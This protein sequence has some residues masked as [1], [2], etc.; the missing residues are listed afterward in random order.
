MLL[1]GIA[2]TVAGGATRLENVHLQFTMPQ[3]IAPEWTLSS[4]FS[5]AIPLV[6]VSLTGQFLPGMA[7]LQGAGYT[8][9]ARPIFAATSI[10][11]AIVALF[12]GITIVIAAITA[13]LCTGSDAHENPGKRYIAG[14]ANGIFYL[15]GGCFAGSIVLL[16]TALPGAFIA[17]LAGL[18]L[19]GAIMAN[20]MG[21]VGEASHREASIITFLVTASGMT[22]QGLGSAFWGVIIGLFT[23]AVLHRPWRTEAVVS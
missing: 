9:P 11:S 7:I 15:V 6:L 3:F 20:L 1:A 12:G 4:T 2:L 22:F 17:I 19:V 5:L 8:V 21:A 18:A 14:I 16:F 10:M 13:A 23:Y